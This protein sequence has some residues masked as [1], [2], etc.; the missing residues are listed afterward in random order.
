MI[1]H[2]RAGTPYIYFTH[3]ETVGSGVTSSPVHIDPGV[4]A[5]RGVSVAATLSTAT[6]AKIQF[7]ISSKADIDAA[8]ANWFDWSHGDSAASASEFFIGP[9]TAV[10][11][12]STGGNT[13]FE[14]LGV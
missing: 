5:A 14:V 3:K 10:R 8:A 4:S 1:N 7:T 2:F 11:C 13:V 9:V 6:S 12:T